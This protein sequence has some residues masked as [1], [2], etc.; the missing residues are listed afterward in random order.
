LA[1]TVV[2]RRTGSA[3]STNRQRAMAAALTSGISAEEGAACGIGG[4]WKTAWR[5][6]RD[7]GK[8]TSGA[9]AQNNA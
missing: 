5:Q 4:G 1:F 6:G 3:A 2:A 8:Q 9:G 7:D